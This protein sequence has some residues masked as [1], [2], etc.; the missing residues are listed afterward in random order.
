MAKIKKTK[1]SINSTTTVL[2]NKIS[3]YLDCTNDIYIRKSNLSSLKRTFQRIRT[4]IGQYL[5]KRCKKC[6]ALFK[7]KRV[8]IK[9]IRI[10][11]TCIECNNINRINRRYS[12]DKKQE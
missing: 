6:G 1:T 7:Q 2:K 4:P 12:D 9:A 5:E 8:R 11:Y 3:S 10:T